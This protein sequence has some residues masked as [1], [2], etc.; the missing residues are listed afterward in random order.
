V[1]RAGARLPYDRGLSGSALIAEVGAAAHVLTPAGEGERILP[2]ALVKTFTWNGDGTLGP[3]TE[4][5]TQPLTEVRR[6]AGNHAGRALA[7]S[8]GPGRTPVKMIAFRL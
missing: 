6:H 3:L 5:S 8:L 7:V 4:G 2:A 1:P